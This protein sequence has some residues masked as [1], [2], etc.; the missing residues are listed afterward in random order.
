MDPHPAL[1]QMSVDE[2]GRSKDADVLQHTL[3]AIAQMEQRGMRDDPR[4]LQLLNIAKQL[5]L[6]SE[7]VPLTSKLLENRHTDGNFHQVGGKNLSCTMHTMEK[8]PFLVYYLIVPDD[9]M[10][11][12]TSSQTWTKLTQWTIMMPRRRREKH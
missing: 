12:L 9:R 10:V 1:E 8:F 6:R 2:D 7:V 3:S 11:W 5:R 4:Y